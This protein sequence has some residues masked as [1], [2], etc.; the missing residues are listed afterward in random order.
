HARPDRALPESHL[1]AAA[2]SQRPADR[3]PLAARGGAAGARG[4]RHRDERNRAC[5][6]REGGCLPARAAGQAQRAAPAEGDRAH[7]Q[8][9]R[10][11]RGAAQ[12]R[13]RAAVALGARVPSNS[14]GRTHH[15]RSC[16]CGSALR[17]AHRRGDRLP[18]SRSSRL[19]RV[20][21]KSMSAFVSYA[22]NGEDFTLW[23]ALHD[24][25]AGT[26]IDIGAYDPDIDSVTRAFYDRG[27]SGINIEPVD[28]Y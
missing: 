12:E 10:R 6:G 3:G 28:A 11:G 15:R 18:A 13:V 7:L 22:Q 27:W 23:C 25:D 1:W 24:V 5:A 26:Y 8:A 2:P 21:G 17:D 19:N 14:Q 4:A 16:V 20:T 9:G